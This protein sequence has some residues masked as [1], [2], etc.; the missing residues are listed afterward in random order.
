MLLEVSPAKHMS[1][2]NALHH[3]WLDPSAICGGGGITQSSTT[4]GDDLSPRLS[5]VS[6]LSELPEDNQNDG[7][8]SVLSVAPPSDDMASVDSFNSSE[9]VPTRRPL[10]R[11]SKVLMRSGARSIG[12]YATLSTLRAATQENDVTM[13]GKNADPVEATV[14]VE[15]QPLAAKCG[16]RSQW[17]GVL[18]WNVASAYNP[19][20]GHIFG[21]NMFSIRE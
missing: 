6:E 2:T 5:D 12:L 21:W 7:D 20:S 10:E 11:C 17:F 18:C 14:E 9:K 8:A 1:L 3:T 4:T 19:Q 13:G 16:R 15:P